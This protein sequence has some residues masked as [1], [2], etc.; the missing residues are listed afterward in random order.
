L[1]SLTLAQEMGQAMAR[2]AGGGGRVGEQRDTRESTGG[3]QYSWQIAPPLCPRAARWTAR[4]ASTGPP[5]TNGEG[6]VAGT[7]RQTFE[8]TRPRATYWS[9]RA[10]A[11]AAGY[12]RSTVHNCNRTSAQIFLPNTP[13]TIGNLNFTVGSQPPEGGSELM[14]GVSRPLDLNYPECRYPQCLR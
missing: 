1:R 13:K 11:V 5:R 9:L 4:R 6:D 2:R 8:T 14:I 12:A 3:C 7:I 10:M